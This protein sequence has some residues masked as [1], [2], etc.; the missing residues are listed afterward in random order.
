MLSGELKHQPYNLFIYIQCQFKIKSSYDIKL[1][2]TGNALI[3]L[4]V[5][6]LLFTECNSFAFK[7]EI[8]AF[9][10]EKFCPGYI[11]NVTPFFAKVLR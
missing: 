9:I 10:R 3:V 2:L 8:Y 7:R 5:V 11:A 4:F 1:K 6:F